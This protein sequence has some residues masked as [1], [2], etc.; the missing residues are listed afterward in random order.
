[1]NRCPD[2]VPVVFMQSHQVHHGVL[3]SKVPPGNI[4]FEVL[5]YTSAML[6]PHKR[7]EV[8]TF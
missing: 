3:A 8:R 4:L 2:G 7:D 6:R 1:M 5:E